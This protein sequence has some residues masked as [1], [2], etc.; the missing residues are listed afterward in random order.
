MVHLAISSDLD[1]QIMAAHAR[2]QETGKPPLEW[3]GFLIGLLR[4]GLQGYLK[5][6]GIEATQGRLVLTPDEVREMPR[7]A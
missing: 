3:G 6:E 7:G 4:A 1:A 5:A 2:Y